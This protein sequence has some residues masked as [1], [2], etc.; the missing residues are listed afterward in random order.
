MNK[1]D[2]INTRKSTAFLLGFTQSMVQDIQK[3]MSVSQSEATGML[4]SKIKIRD[5]E[6]ID[7]F[8]CI[9]ID[10]TD[11]TL[12]TMIMFFDRHNYYLDAVLTELNL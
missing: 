12:I 9:G 4:V 10:P 2:Q 7:Y 11:P 8:D 3:N 5:K 1:I 6:T